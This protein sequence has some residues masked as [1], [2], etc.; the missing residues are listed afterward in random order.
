MVR[1][2]TSDNLVFLFFY[3]FYFFIFYPFCNHLLVMWWG[4]DRNPFIAQY[5]CPIS[6]V[7]PLQIVLY[8]STN[9][10]YRRQYHVY[11]VYTK[12]GNHYHNHILFRYFKLKIA[13]EI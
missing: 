6:T 13:T 7:V 9:D 3:F 5:P 8:Q 12:I 4:N 10:G 2:N 11:L 1:F